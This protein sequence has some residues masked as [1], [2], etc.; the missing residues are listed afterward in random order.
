[1]V[2]TPD[3]QTSQSELRNSATHSAVDAPTSFPVVPTPEAATATQERQAVVHLKLSVQKMFCQSPKLFHQKKENCH[4]YI[5]SVQR[6]A[7]SY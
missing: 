4:I 1:M 3:E 5:I 7:S 6:K 2:S